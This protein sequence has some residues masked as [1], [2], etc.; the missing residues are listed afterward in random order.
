[1]NIVEAMIS[2]ASRIQLP[3]FL[4]H[5][6]RV[7]STEVWRRWAGQDVARRPATAVFDYSIARK[8]ANVHI[9][10]SAISQ[11]VSMLPV[12]IMG[13]EVVKGVEREFDDNDHPAN[14]LLR[15]PNPEMTLREVIRHDVTSYLGGNAFSTIERATGPN[16]KIELWPRD[17]RFV[18]IKLKNNRP[19]GYIFGEF[20]P[21]RIV[22]PTNRVLHIR[23]MAPD[24]PFYG[25]P[26]HES[27]RAE[28]EMDQA[29]N[30]FNSMFFESGATLNMMFTPNTLLKDYQHDQLLDQIREQTSGVQRA[31]TFLINKYPGTL[32]FPDQKHSDIA[33]GELLKMNREK[34]FGAYHLPPFRGG[35]MQY[36]NYANALAQDADFWV[37]TIMPITATIADAYNKQLIWPIYGDDVKLAF[38][39]SMVPALQGDKKQ[40]AEVHQIYVN[41][42]VL[43]PNEVREDLGMK[44]LKE[45][46]VKDPDEAE[47]LPDDADADADDPDDSEENELSRVIFQ[48][49][50]GQGRRA[51]GELDK[52]VCHGNAMSMIFSPELTAARIVKED[53]ET[54]ALLNV[55]ALRLN[56]K[57]RQAASR[58]V[59]HVDKALPYPTNTDT[60]LRDFQSAYDKRAEHCKWF[61]NSLCEDANKQTRAQLTTT[62]ADTDRFNQSFVAMNKAVRLSFNSSRA[63]EMAVWL[64]KQATDYGHSVG[65]DIKKEIQA[66]A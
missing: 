22:Y 21:Q 7:K 59:I 54:P 36:A 1:M 63:T 2:I 64:I 52:A 58:A 55:I 39:F 62:L 48:F 60:Q 24:D 66:V 45:V 29:I 49:M 6:D 46:A 33:F 51:V 15:N 65:N 35:V 10:V 18:E 8:N 47:P 16:A 4:T 5:K 30:L 19:V 32:E 27:V 17:P 57:I 43:T 11:A 42:G 25:I 44:P 53:H 28:I 61:I 38:D 12:N 14:D 9:A 50:R 3:G 20:T 56:A 23:D 31:F 34:I 26:R 41:I 37:N 13:T 40:Q